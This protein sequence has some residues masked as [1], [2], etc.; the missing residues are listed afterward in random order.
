MDDSK[1]WYT[2]RTIWAALV[3]GLAP[4]LG[5]V[6]HVSLDAGTTQQ[7]ID[8]ITTAATVGAS[9]IAIIGRVKATTTIGK[10][11]P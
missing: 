9:V 8:A 10:P 6:F 4:L 1:P 5:I 7:I 11:S 2:S 3:T